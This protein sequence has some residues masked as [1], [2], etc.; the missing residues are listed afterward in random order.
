LLNAR[1]I[2]YRLQAAGAL[3]MVALFRALPLDAASAVGGWLARRIGPLV[4]AHRT[5]RN[6]LAAAMPEL[7]AK[8]RGAILAG[9]WD[10]IGRTVAEYPHLGRLM[11]DAA[12][13]EIIDPAGLA[14]R[15]RDDGI[16]A[17]LVGMHYG[18]WEL[19]TV[20]G[21]RAGLAQRHFYRAPNNPY[22]DRLLVRLRAAM[23]QEG[24]L[25]KGAPG[26]RLAVALLR[27]GTHLGMLVDQKQDEGIAAPFFGRD[28]MTTT[29]PAALA[30]RLGVPVAAAQV[31]R[32]KGARF[33]IFVHEFEVVKTADREADVAVTTR[34]IN[35]R[36]ESWVREHPEQ[37]FWVHRRWPKALAG[38]SSSVLS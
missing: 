24:Y 32:L 36:L 10:N 1:D 38:D 23:Q 33:R 4:G 13:V 8:A 34:L 26:A 29:A 25:P 6:N 27:A 37:W 21:F 7:D 22:V 18:N 3:A 19:S 28:A 20:P 12:R 11:R 16:G 35:A 15:L 2:A 5:A 17:L 9:M 31:V 14:A 30:R